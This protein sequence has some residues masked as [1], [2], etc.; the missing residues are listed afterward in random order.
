MDC[1][2]LYSLDSKYVFITYIYSTYDL[3]F[4]LC[5]EKCPIDKKSFPTLNY[6]LSFFGI[7]YQISRILFWYI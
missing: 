3:F 1:T 4:I 5:M 7:E 2:L 6:M